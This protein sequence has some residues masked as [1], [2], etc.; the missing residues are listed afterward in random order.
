MLHFLGNKIYDALSNV[1][2]LYGRLIYPEDFPGTKVS[3]LARLDCIRFRNYALN[4]IDNLHF[5]RLGMNRTYDIHLTAVDE[6]DDAISCRL[7]RYVEAG[8]RITSHKIPHTSVISLAFV[9]VIS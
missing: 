8:P 7:S 5:L 9:K 2:Q 1:I 4:E 6:D 3:G